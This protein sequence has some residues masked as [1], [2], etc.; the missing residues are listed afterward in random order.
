MRIKQK[1]IY[2]FL[3][4]MVLMG[5]NQILWSQN[6]QVTGVVTDSEGLPLPG[7][8]ILEKGTLNGA[9][10]DFEGNY[11][12]S[13]SPNSI[14]VFSYMGFDTKEVKVGIQKVINIVLE[15]SLMG[16]EEVT[17]VAYGRQ[18]KVT[19]TG[20]ISSIDSDELAKSPAANVANSLAG[21]VTGLSTVQYSGQPGADDPSIYLRGV[22]TLSE[23][24]SQPLMIVDGVERSFMSLDPEEIG[25][26]TI[27]KDASATAVYGVRGA[28]G[29]IIVTTKRGSEGK[30]KISASFSRGMQQPTRLLDF[31][32]SYTYAQRYNEAQ[33]ND[34]PDLDPSQ[35]K[36][37][38][39]AIEAF[40]TNSNPLIYPNTDWMDYL[41]KPSASQSKG[42]L[43]ISG[44]TDKVKYFVSLGILNQDGLFK[45]YDS[46]YDYNFSFQRYNYRSNIDIKITETTK[47]GVTIGG[48]AG[49]TNRPNTKNNFNE[50][51]RD[52]YW[53][54]P[55]SGAGIVDGKYMTSS[56]L[57]IPG[58]DI[59]N[60][61]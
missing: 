29:V 28:N 12:I 15:S 9:A 55:Y 22:A 27:L 16:L 45:T 38:P 17:V 3:T 35:L 25:S 41:L 24:E 59:I 39:E 7:V 19:V 23:G 50:L 26:I 42:N 36:F 30:A 37:S 4:L 33:L 34:D 47:L 56:Q 49:V 48:Q 5:V 61:V 13:V 11:Q 31:A 60:A 14:L 8:T 40:R 1:Q 57:Y 46:Q 6:T 54:V 20:A 52:I 18:K 51:F 10:S 58:T 44:G 32:D 2:L 21:K 43:N 53:S